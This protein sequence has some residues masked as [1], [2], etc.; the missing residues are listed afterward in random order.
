MAIVSTAAKRARRQALWD[1]GMR[2]CWICKGPL[3][4]ATMT[5]DHYVPSSR[6]GGDEIENLRPAHARC[7]EERGNEMPK[8]AKEPPVSRGVCQHCYRIPVARRRFVVDKH[9]RLLCEDRCA[10]AWERFVAAVR[11]LS[12]GAR[13]CAREAV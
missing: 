2:V 4:L 11:V 10:P 9:A 6:G 8:G 7:N 3:T 1:A 5:L 13:E 12:L